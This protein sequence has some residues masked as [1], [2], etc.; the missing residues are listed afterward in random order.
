MC[1]HLQAECRIKH[2]RYCLIMIIQKYVKRM[3]ICLAR[4]RVC[5]I[6]IARINLQMRYRDPKKLVFSGVSFKA[7][8]E[9]CAH[10]ET[11]STIKHARYSLIIMIIQKHV[12]RMPIC[13]ARDRVCV[14]SIVRHFCCGSG[15]CWIDY[16]SVSY[17][18]L[19]NQCSLY[20][21]KIRILKKICGCGLNTG[22][23]NR[24]K[25]TV[26]HKSSG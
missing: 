18:R 11:E 2:A 26:L 8:S 21:D 10:L 3:L 7:V 6:S 20:V 12:K 25:I 13:F 16:S 22:A 15:V 19:I 4:D 5:T 1:A 24:P 23:L 14:I 9:I 17:V